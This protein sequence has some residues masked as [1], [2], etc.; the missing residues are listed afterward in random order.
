MPTYAHTSPDGVI[1][2]VIV[3][4][5]QATAETLAPAGCAAVEIDGT[6]AG[7]GWTHDPEVTDPE[8]AFTPPEPV[9]PDPAP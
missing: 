2:N 6:P 9:E 3:A 8:E 7:I 5:D 1:L 4:D